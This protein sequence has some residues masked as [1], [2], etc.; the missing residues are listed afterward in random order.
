MV[1]LG[2]TEQ[3]LHVFVYGAITLCGAPFQKLQLTSRF[4]TL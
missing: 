4:V 1:I 2:N 3:S